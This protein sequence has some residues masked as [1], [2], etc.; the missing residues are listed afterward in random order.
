MAAP[1]FAEMPEARYAGRYALKAHH[2]RLLN[3]PEWISLFSNL[4]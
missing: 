4:G 2:S 3:I 1:A